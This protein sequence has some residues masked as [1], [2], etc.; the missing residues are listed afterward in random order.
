MITPAELAG[1]PLFAALPH[2]LRARL[3]ARAADIHANPG[4]WISYEGDTPYFWVLLEGEVERVRTLAGRDV[5]V[6]TFDPGEYFGEIPLMLGT[7]SFA[8]IRAFAA[9]TARRSLGP[10]TM[11]SVSPTFSTKIRSRTRV[12]GS[13]K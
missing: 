10:G 12:T 4:E 2:A 5:Q 1:V 8:A 7:E 11:P 13:K 9:A 3:A 6:T